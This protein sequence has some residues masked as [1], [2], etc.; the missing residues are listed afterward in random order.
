MPGMFQADIMSILNSSIIFRNFSIQHAR[1]RFALCRSPWV[2]QG[3]GNAL[4]MRHSVLGRTDLRCMLHGD[5]QPHTGAGRQGRH[6]WHA[7]AWLAQGRGIRRRQT[8][9]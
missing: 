1:L 2:G 4:I 8:K 9:K 7:I 5:A 3:P 6:D